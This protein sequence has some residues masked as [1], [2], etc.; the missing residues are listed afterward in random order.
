[1]KGKRIL[2]IIVVMAMVLTAVPVLSGNAKAANSNVSN[3]PS[4]LVIG[5]LAIGRW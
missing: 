4:Y 5:R 3:Y 1:M 2:G